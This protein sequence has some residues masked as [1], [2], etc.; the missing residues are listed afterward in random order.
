MSF[1]CLIMGESGTGKTASLRNLDPKQTLLIQPVRKPLPFRSPDWREIRAKGDSGNI[2]VTADPARMIL[3]MQRAPQ[4]I[5]VIDDFQYILIGAYMARRSEK[6]YEKFSEF[7]GMGYDVVR[8]S[9]ELAFEKR[10]YILGHS[11]TDDFG[12]THLKTIGKMLDQVIVLEG[13]FTTVLRTR[14]D[15]ASGKYFFRT[16]ND[17]NDTVKSPIGMFEDDEVENDLAAVDA[18]I[19]EYYGITEMA[20]AEESNNEPKTE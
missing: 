4:K 15:A 16:H 7:A 18:R 14:V 20:V 6:S 3:A 12:R 17:G 8:A 13:L 19:C 5:I 10:V 1:S 2:Y 9:T 11:T